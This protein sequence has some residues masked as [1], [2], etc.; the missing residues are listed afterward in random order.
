MAGSITDSLAKLSVY[1]ENNS[2]ERIAS[3]VEGLVRTLLVNADGDRWL[4][5]SAILRELAEASP[6][7]FLA[8]LE[9]SLPRECDAPVRQIIER[10][11]C[12]RAT[13]T[14]GLVT[15]HGRNRDAC[16]SAVWGR[17]MS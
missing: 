9:A 12:R 4:S 15:R 14:G 1:A 7:N 16:V 8:A 3:G 10:L 6:E 11:H 5:V 17:R 2:D 13:C